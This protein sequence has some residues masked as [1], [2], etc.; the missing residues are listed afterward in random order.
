MPSGSVVSSEA[1]FCQYSV[2]VLVSISLG[3]LP[4]PRNSEPFCLV[5][6]ILERRRREGEGVLGEVVVLV[7]RAGARRLGER[8]VAEHAADAGD[9]AMDAV[10][11]AAALLI[12]VEALADMVAQDSGRPG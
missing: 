11:H 6:R 12:A 4:S 3:S 8:R 2:E 1:P 9:M 10:E 5:D 7:L